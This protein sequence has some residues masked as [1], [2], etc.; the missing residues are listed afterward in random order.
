M[1]KNKNIF[2]LENNYL[3]VEIDKVGG[4]LNSVILK[5]TGTEY[6]WQ[7]D[8]KYW[9]EKAPNL[10]PF[11]GRLFNGKFTHGGKSYEMKLHGFLRNQELEPIK[12]DKDEIILNLEGEKWVDENK[13]PFSF[14]L[15]LSFK[16]DKKEIICTYEIK[17]K[18]SET[19]YFSVGGHPGIN[20]S[21]ESGLRFEDYRIEFPTECKPNR[22]VF[23][24]AGLTTEERPSFILDENK[25]FNL[26]H[27]LFDN[28]A[29]VLTDTPHEVKLKSDKG[30]HF[31][32]LH[33]DD[34]PYIGFWHADK[35]DA[36]YVCLEPWTSL[37]GR[38]GVEEEISRM[39]DR[40]S[41]KSGESKTISW[42]LEIN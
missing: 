29:I 15:N 40:I 19:M 35:M 8:K 30:K 12:A 24:A 14:N 34:M 41:I 39:D 27:S 3:K 17:N 32:T 21:L 38:D 2:T 16:L 23:S 13:Y 11:I 25:G 5:E 31:V 9:D 33:Y 6:L 26:E 28:D 36:P 42:S 37:P 22:V 20:L 18:S 4:S 10:F 1:S 7:G